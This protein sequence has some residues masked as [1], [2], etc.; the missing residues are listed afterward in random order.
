MLPSVF[1]CSPHTFSKVSCNFPPGSLACKKIMV[2]LWH[3]PLHIRGPLGPAWDCPGQL[4][5]GVKCWGYKS[6]LLISMG[7]A[8]PVPNNEV[9]EV[10]GL[11]WRIRGAQSLYIPKKALALDCFLKHDL[12]TPGISCLIKVSLFTWGFNPCQ[13]VWLM[14]NARFCS[15]GTQGNAILF[16]R[17]GSLMSAVAHQSMGF[18]RQ[19]YWSGLPFS[20]PGDLSDPGI[21][22]APPV[23]PALQADSLPTEPSGK[24]G[25]VHLGP[26]AML[27]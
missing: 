19:E 11:T 24:P 4:V 18:F 20:A 1:P 17:S 14:V 10:K 22:P 9:Y 2:K 5:P 13:V 16:A 7:P 23:S 12:W 8:S 27:Y 25:F 15:P 3:P 21:K 26:R 6:S